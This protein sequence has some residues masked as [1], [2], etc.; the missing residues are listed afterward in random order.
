MQNLEELKSQIP[1]YAKDTKINLSTLLSQENQV[2]TPKQVFGAALTSAYVTKEKL[3]IRIIKNEAEKVLSES[4][5]KAVKS[6][7]TLMAMNN[8]YY[9]FTHISND[10][11]YSQMPAGL[12]MQGIVNHGI[13]KIDFEI[14]SLA[15]SI[16]NGCGMC[17][18]AHAGQLVKNGLS[19][20]QIQMV[21]K[22]AAVVSSASQLLICEAGD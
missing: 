7:S 3:L 21:A 13:D 16:I 15:A 2:L 4:E 14:F 19:K 22:L 10:K 9:R 11:E 12:R 5:M 8:I 18:D 1:D 17:I 20:N 6:A